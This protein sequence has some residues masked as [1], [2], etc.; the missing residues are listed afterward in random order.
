NVSSAP[1]SSVTTRLGFSSTKL[2]PILCA[3]EIWCPEVESDNFFDA[4]WHPHNI[5]GNT[6]TK[7]HHRYVFFLS[8]FILLQFFVS[9][10][11]TDQR[12]NISGIFLAPGACFSTLRSDDT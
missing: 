1:I 9:L 11:S 10:S 2:S 4:P 5:S 8:L 12:A 3:M 6:I 7:R